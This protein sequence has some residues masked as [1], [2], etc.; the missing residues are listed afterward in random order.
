MSKRTDFI[1]WQTFFMNTAILSSMRSK[2]PVTQVGACIV[3]TSNKLV[4]IGFNGFPVGCSDDVFPWG[5][6]SPNEDENKYAY[7]VHAEVNAILNGNS[8]ISGC[9]MYTTHFPCRECVKIIIQSGIISIFYLNKRTD[10]ASVK[11][12]DAVNIAYTQLHLT[13]KIVLIEC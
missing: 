7:S 6:D 4:S 10:L 5:K 12:L 11:M 2:D 8:N 3:D 13:K 9:I 1:S